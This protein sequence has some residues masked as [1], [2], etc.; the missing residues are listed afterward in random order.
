VKRRKY[1]W[2]DRETHF[3]ELEIFKNFKKALALGRV[4]LGEGSDREA[5]KSFMELLKD[6]QWKVNQIESMRTSLIG[7]SR[8]APGY[9]KVL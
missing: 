7:I 9:N 1:K 2:T 4:V 5:N 8:S 6:D 3:K